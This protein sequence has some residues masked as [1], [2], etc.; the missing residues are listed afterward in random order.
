M[1]RVASISATL[2]LQGSDS[3][4]ERYKSISKFRKHGDSSTLIGTKILQTGI[5]IEEITHFINARG[6]KSEIATLQ[7]LG[8]ALRRHDSKDKVFIY[9]FMDKENYLKQH[10]NARKR[11]YEKEGHEVTVL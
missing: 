4:G 7:A 3:L 11:H 6:M 8:R 10:S 1:A 9:D 5:N 2:L